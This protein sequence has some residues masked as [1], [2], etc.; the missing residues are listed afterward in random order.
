MTMISRVDADWVLD[1]RALPTVEA[2]VHLSDGRSAFAQAPSGA[3]KG[4]HESLELRDGDPAHFRGKGVRSAI[5]QVRDVISPAL[6]GM[7]CVEL[8]GLD[9]RM[10]EIDG[11]PDRSRL[12]A[13]AMVA[14]SAA[15]ARAGAMVRG[16]ELWQHLAGPSPLIP[17]PMVN[18]F[19]GNLHA[20]GGMSI[21]DILVV[22]VGAPDIETALEWVDDVYW[23]ASDIL[24]ERGASRLVGDEGGF[25]APTPSSEA[26]LAL[27]VEA[28]ARAGRHPGAEVALAL[29]I[30]AAHLL[31]PD[32]SY[33]VD[34]MRLTTQDMIGTIKSWVDRYPIVSV[35]D[36]LS[37]DDWGG[38]H[39]LATSIAGQ[40]QVLG[41][42]L[43]CT[44]IDRLERAVET[45]CANAVLVK[46]NQ[47]GTISEA[48]AVAAR[49]RELGARAVVSARSGETEDD[50]LAD[51]AVASGAGQIK[52]GSVAR[53]ERLAKYNRLLRIS[54]SPSSPPWSGANGLL[55]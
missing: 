17:L 7:D 24:N 6:I 9:A 15:L 26:A 50:W 10:I 2:T 52:I 27:S 35:E 8:E 44:R 11:T 28:I 21:Q 34:E 29:D 51:L 30:A 48:L 19:S 14:V 45:K 32:G 22:P 55:R 5:D 31:Q 12:G 40:V 36:A 42:D 18:L 20:K 16:V 33:V 54:R 46:A 38:W 47:I 43:L 39:R 41:D 25:G 13:N 4:R 37:E 1:S 23:S 3:S 49:A 53:S